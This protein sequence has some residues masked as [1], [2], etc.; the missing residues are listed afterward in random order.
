[1]DQPSLVRYVDPA[2]GSDRGSGSQAAPFRS[3]T[4]ALTQLSPQGTLRLAAGTYSAETFPIRLPKGVTLLGD[5]PRQGQGVVIRGGGNYRSPTFGLQ[6]VTLVLANQSVLRGV[7]VTNPQANGTGAWVESTDPTI[8]SCRFQGCRREGVFVLGSA[9]P[10]IINTRFERND[11][12]GIFLMR[13]AKGELRQN[14]CRNTGFGIAISD[15]AAPLVADNHLVDNRSGIVLS[16]RCRPVLRDNRVQRSRA[17]GLTILD[18]AQP[19][20]GDAQSPGGNRLEGSS[21]FDVNNSGARVL[22][23]AGNQVHPARVS[24]SIVF[25]PVLQPPSISAAEPPPS[26]SP[27]SPNPEPSEGPS[28]APGLQAEFP[29]IADSWAEPFILS[30]T[31]RSVIRGFPDGTFRPNAPLTRAQLAVLLTQACPLAP[32][33]LAQTFSDVSEDY[34]GY[35]AIQRATRTGFITG[36]PDGTFRPEAPLTRLQTMLALNSGL[37]LTGGTPEVLALYRDRA[38]IPSWAVA[39]VVAVTQNRIVVNHPSP[40]LL[41][42]LRTIS[43]AEV[44]AMIYQGLVVRGEAA[45]ISSPFIISP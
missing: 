28:P 34:W 13:Q 36:F 9:R 15:E 21:R 31:K 22:V 43:R 29:D 45:A 40:D 16:R 1:M 25:Q 26:L 24:G 39:A 10:L 20:L 5:E 30:L 3:I 27:R 7:T 4:H 35:E 6:S 38:E 32:R 23:S 44:S 37:Q 12:S 19:D 8:Q 18:Q 42:P 41:A 14:L 17:D 11:A 33:R 2:R